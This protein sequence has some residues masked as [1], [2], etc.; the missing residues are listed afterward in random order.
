MIMTSSQK[1]NND[2]IGKGWC[3]FAK[4]KAVILNLQMWGASAYRQR[5]HQLSRCASPKFIIID[6]RFYKPKDV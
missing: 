4:Q 1:S 6:E 5:I 3:E 2:H